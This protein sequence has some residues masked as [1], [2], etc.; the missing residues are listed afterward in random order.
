MD[1]MPETMLLYPRH[2]D[3]DTTSYSQLKANDLN[4]K[5]A[6]DILVNRQIKQERER[7]GEAMICNVVDKRDGDYNPH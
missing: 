5:L 2:A 4:S 1:V 3:R 7:K 6:Q